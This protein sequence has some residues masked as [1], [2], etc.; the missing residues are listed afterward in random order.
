MLKILFKALVLLLIVIS[1]YLIVHPQAC[2]NMLAG[3]ER[4]MVGPGEQVQWRHPMAEP[5][6]DVRT[7]GQKTPSTAD[8]MLNEEGA[9]QNETEPQTQAAAPAQ[10]TYSQEDIDYA[11]AS[12]YVELEREYAGQKQEGK[13][14]LQ[15]LSNIVMKDFEMTPAEW[16][17]FLARA[18]ASDLFEKVRQEQAANAAAEAT[19][20]K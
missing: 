11:I 6:K 8:E 12:R 1:V 13:D 14:M 2:S 4:V 17:A 16:N 15:N 19:A 5:Q 9:A 20:E 7:H 18:T 10:K 3:R